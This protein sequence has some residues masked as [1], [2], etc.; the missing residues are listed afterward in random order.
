MEVSTVLWREFIFFRRRIEELSFCHHEPCFIPH[1]FGWG[2]ADLAVEG[3]T[4]AFSHTRLIAMT[5]MNTGF[6]AVSSRIITS[7]L[8]ERSF[9]YYLH[10]P[11]SMPSCLLAT[12]CREH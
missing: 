6:N 11:I 5:T 9:E 3:A 4:H 1:C 8:Y 10:L 12:Y 7:K 2:F